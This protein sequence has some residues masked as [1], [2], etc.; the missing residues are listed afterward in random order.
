MLPMI[1]D[2]ILTPTKKSEPN[3]VRLW[4]RRTNNKERSGVCYTGVNK[5]DFSPDSIMS[6]WGQNWLAAKEKFLSKEGKK[7][8]LVCVGRLSP[9]KGVDGKYLVEV[10]IYFLA[11]IWLDYLLN[12][13][14][15][16]FLPLSSAIF[17]CSF[18]LH[19]E[20]IN[21]LKKLPDC[22]LWL[23]GDGPFRPELESISNGLPVKF[24]GYQSGE[25]LHAVYS[26]ADLFVCPSLTETFGQTVNEALA[27]QVRVALPN[28]PVFV[29]AYGEI[30]PKT[31]FW[32][33]LDQEDMATCITKTLRQHSG[34]D[35]NMLKSW[36]DA[37]VALLEE[38]RQAFEDREHTFTLL[39]LI[40]FPLWCAVTISTVISFFIFSQ[41]RSFCG[42]SVRIFCKTV[43]KDVLIKVQSLQSLPS[44]G[45][46]HRME[47]G[48]KTH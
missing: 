28:V 31:A 12:L 22:A 16:V 13:L 42:G 29:E 46:L 40:Y 20:L 33:P 35:L 43:A 26:V 34:P 38:Y 27:S 15:C 25:A 1:S 17:I 5:R 14:Y 10:C 21:V 45:S 39:S 6:K 8:L 44:T 24:L 37:C 2:R 32:N 41:I 23:V 11:V 7:Y 48:G 3:L 36:D 4:K 9:E 47:V 19:K 18:S 30:I